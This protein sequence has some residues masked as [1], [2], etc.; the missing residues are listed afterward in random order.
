L[1][2][3]F[4]LTKELIIKPLE[5]SKLENPI[6]AAHYLLGA[7]IIRTLPSGEILKAKIV[8]TE[9]Y[10]QADPASHTHRGKT[11]R[12][13]AMFG[14]AGRAY[15]YFTYGMHWC[16]NVTAGQEGEGAGVLIRAAEPLEGAEK[17]RALRG[18]VE[19]SQL[20]NGPAKLA[21][22]LAIDKKLY[23]HDLT[24]SPLKIV[25]GG[26]VKKS[27]ISISPRIGIS[28]SVDELLRFYITNSKYVSKQ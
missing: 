15:V 18:G 7:I 25:G 28:R 17:M 10:H 8:E 27:E 4:L 13:K 11:P 9:S 23:G 21:Q 5:K 12:N 6:A 19:P 2:I 26:L 14:P 16:F 3:N 1:T 22:A 20:T 24:K